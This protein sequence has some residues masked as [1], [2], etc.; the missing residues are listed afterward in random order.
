[1]ALSVFR[2]HLTSASQLFVNLSAE[3]SGGAEVAKKVAWILEDLGS[4]RDL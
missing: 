4:L 1:M 3:A 2:E